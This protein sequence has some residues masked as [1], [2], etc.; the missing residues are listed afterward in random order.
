[1]VS[2]STWLRRSTLA[3]QTSSL[4]AMGSLAMV[5]KGA[6]LIENLTGGPPGF[7]LGNVYVMAGVPSIMR[8]MLASLENHLSHGAMAL[9]RSI[10]AYL[11]E[12]AIAEPLRLLQATHPKVQIGSYP[13]NRDGRYG[14]TLVLRGTDQQELELVAQRTSELLVKA[15][16]PIE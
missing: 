14:T 11:A 12:G 1:M 3:W 6:G 15:G 13:F 4:R 7:F 5:P 9:S 8:V 2:A 10:D 16:A